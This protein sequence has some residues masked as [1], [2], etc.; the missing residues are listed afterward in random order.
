MKQQIKLWL[1]DIRDP[2]KFGRI[3]WHWVKTY[4]E[5]IAAFDTYY[6]T[7]ASLDHDLTTEQMLG[8]EDNEKTGHD[9]VCWMEERGIFPEDGVHVHSA[10]PSG[11]R[12]MV[13]GLQAICRRNEIPERMVTVWSADLRRDP[14]PG[15]DPYEPQ[16]RD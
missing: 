4:E 7:Q 3:G 12:R 15:E 14:Y 6:V 1:D 8:H 10:N 11:A 16:W 9:V 13:A 5:A 2:A